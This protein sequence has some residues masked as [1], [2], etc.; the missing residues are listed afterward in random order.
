MLFQYI[1]D[2][3]ED[4]PQECDTFDLHFVLNGEPIDVLDKRVIKKLIGNKTFKFEPALVAPKPE[5]PAQESDERSFDV[6]V[7]SEG[8][9]SP[10]VV[11][12]EMP[13][14]KKRGRKAKG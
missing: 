6:V 9:A 3:S 4:A 8:E 2:G 12:F 7:E 11:N 1:G 13:I 10:E 5:F 14:A